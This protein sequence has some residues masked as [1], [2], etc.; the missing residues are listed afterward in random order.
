MSAMADLYPDTHWSV[1]LDT[2]RSDAPQKSARQKKPAYVRLRLLAGGVRIAASEA[3]ASLVSSDSS[4][5]SQ[6]DDSLLTATVGCFSRWWSWIAFVV[7]GLGTGL[8][9]DVD[10]FR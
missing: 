8:R 10:L 3:M 7:T 4:S 9:L 5:L 1:N 2:A 6:A